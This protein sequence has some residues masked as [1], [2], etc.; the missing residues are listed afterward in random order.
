MKQKEFEELSKNEVKKL[1]GKQNDED[2]T[3]AW[4]AGY[5]Y[6]QELIRSVYQDYYQDE[7][8]DKIENFV[9]DELEVFKK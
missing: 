2:V 5:L 7:F 6:A 8:F 1:N 3:K 4:R 9:E